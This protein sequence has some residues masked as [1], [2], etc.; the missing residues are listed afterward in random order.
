VFDDDVIAFT[1]GGNGPYYGLQLREGTHESIL[2]IQAV[3]NYWLMEFL[4]RQSAT[5]H[6]G[7]YYSHG[8]QF[9]ASL[10]IYKIDFNDPL[11][12]AMH[13]EIVSRTRDLMVLTAEKRASSTQYHKEILDRAINAVSNQIENILDS[14]YGLSQED[15]VSE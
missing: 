13:D 14:F 9:I 7:D 11:E 5:K 12:V 4:V 1:G 3:L 6:R 15:R 10:P 8:K 2:Y